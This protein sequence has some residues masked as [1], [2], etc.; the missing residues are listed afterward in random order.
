MR[1]SFS[2]AY[3][4]GALLNVTYNA[5][6]STPELLKALRSA[7]SFA[8]L[9][10]FAGSW[11]PN[12]IEREVFDREWNK[13][14]PAKLRSTFYAPRDGSVIRESQAEAIQAM[15]PQLRLKW[16]RRHPIGVIL[17]DAELQQDGVLAELDTLP[18][19]SARCCVW[20]ETCSGLLSGVRIRSEIPYSSDLVRRLA[21]MGTPESLLAILGRMRLAQLRGEDY[22]VDFEYELALQQALPTCI[23]RSPH[24]YLAHEALLEAIARFLTW[25]P[26]ADSRHFMRVRH[27]NFEHLMRL[28]VERRLA[29]EVPMMGWPGLPLPP[30]E[31]MK[32]RKS[33]IDAWIA[34]NAYTDPGDQLDR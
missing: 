26:Y 21:S 6:S 25:A 34:K 9:A 27:D 10:C 2:D 13:N 20:D 23:A 32:L 14:G 15:L 19:G 28:D 17:C 5:P 16:W 18:E 22:V 1:S 11:E 3:A 29:E 12:S 4:P 24:L 33:T 31:Q 30:S 8:E 7:G